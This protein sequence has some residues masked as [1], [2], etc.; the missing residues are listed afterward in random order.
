MSTGGAAGAGGEG[1]SVRTD[2]GMPPVVCPLGPFTGMYSGEHHPTTGG[3]VVKANIAGTISLR[4]VAATKTT[5]TVTATLMFPVGTTMG[6]ITGTARGTFDCAEGMGSLSLPTPPAAP[7]TVTTYIPTQLFN[8][9]EGSFDIQLDASGHPGGTFSI[10]ET[11]NPTLAT[12]SG[13]W[14]AS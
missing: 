13:T 8:A 12:G 14:S 5:A 4:F 2:A 6:G 3:T 10:R 1:G 7:A 9:I 11:L